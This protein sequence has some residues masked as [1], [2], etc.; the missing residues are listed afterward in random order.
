MFFFG[1]FH[2]FSR[3]LQIAH[4]NPRPWKNIPWPWTFKC[5]SKPK[6][7]GLWGVWCQDALGSEKKQA[8]TE[9]HC[10]FLAF[11]IWNLQVYSIGWLTHYPTTI[12]I[13]T[14]RKTLGP[15]LRRIES[16]TAADEPKSEGHCAVKVW[17]TTQR[18]V[19]VGGWATPLKNMKVS[20]DDYSQYMG[21]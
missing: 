14:L 18:N 11:R 5:F 8:N 19:L 7:L 3:R 2:R 21:K 12:S 4:L 15:R 9:N 20:W 16:R 17:R 1:S 13:P 10:V 6:A